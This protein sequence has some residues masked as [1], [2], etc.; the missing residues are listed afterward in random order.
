MFQHVSWRGRLLSPKSATV[1]CLDVCYIYKYLQVDM[2]T[3][4]AEE[5]T[6]QIYDAKKAGLRSLFIGLASRSATFCVC[7]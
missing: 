3:R 4:P 5:A 2:N 6:W 1:A 7:P